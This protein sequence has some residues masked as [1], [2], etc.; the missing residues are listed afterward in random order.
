MA[1]GQVKLDPTE[2]FTRNFSIRKLLDLQEDLRKAETTLWNLIFLAT[3]GT[4]GDIVEVF[5]SEGSPVQISASPSPNFRFLS[6]PLPPP[7]LPRVFSSIPTRPVPVCFNS[8][9]SI[10]FFCP[11]MTPKE[12]EEFI[13]RISE[14]ELELIQKL[15]ISHYTYE[16]MKNK[17]ILVKFTAL[18]ELIL[19][20]EFTLPGDPEPK[21]P[22]A[23][24]HPQK[25]FFHSTSSTESRSTNQWTA[26]DLRRIT[27]QELI[28][29]HQENDAWPNGNVQVDVIS[30]ERD[31]K[32]M[33]TDFPSQKHIDLVS[34]KKEE[35]QDAKKVAEAKEKEEDSKFVAE[36][37]DGDDAA[38]E[39]DQLEARLKKVR[40]EDSRERTDIEMTVDEDMQR[41]IAEME[42]KNADRK[43][44][45][46]GDK[47]WDQSDGAVEDG[48]AAEDD[49]AAEDADTHE[50]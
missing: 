1:P 28:E 6:S 30:I 49:G 42:R 26:Q 37:T 25:I 48:D 34:K 9:E 46:E 36:Q 41:Q 24:P 32:L 2:H 29:I 23:A 8:E 22:T 43:R 40:F 12:I 31:G 3:D 33:K 50:E 19:V 27:Q 45:A 15:A 20:S 14:A 11:L 13:E 39:T 47:Q 4:I 18:R 21:G 17:N 35:E 5:W 7:D 10:L 38:D 44:E 16:D